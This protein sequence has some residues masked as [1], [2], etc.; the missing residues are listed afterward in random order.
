[1]W[2][3]I[4][5][6]TIFVAVTNLCYGFNPDNVQC[7]N[8]MTMNPQGVGSVEPQIMP[9]PY[10]IHVA[11][12]DRG[13][14]DTRKDLN[15]N[16]TADHTEKG[17]RSFMIQARRVDPNRRTG[18]PIG[19]FTSLDSAVLAVEDCPGTYGA[20]LVSSDFS[21][22]RNV[23]LVWNSFDTFQGH[24][25]FRVTFVQDETTF[26]VR[27]KSVTIYDPN[28]PI[29]EM[30][31][32][33][34]ILA[35]IRTIDV[36]DCGSKKGCYRMPEGCREIECEYIV[37]WRNINAGTT[38]FEMSAITDGFNDRYFALGLSTDIYMGDD[39]VFECVHN[40]TS[41]RVEVFQSINYKD[42]TN[43]RLIKPK[44]GL[45]SEEGSYNN[46]R[47]RCRFRRDNRVNNEELTNYGLISRPWRLLMARGP[48]HRGNILPHDIVVGHLPLA[49]PEE[50]SL[51]VGADITGR[52]RYHLVKAHACLMLLAWIFF[53]PI[54]L[55]WMKYYTTMWPN[56]R[57]L[58]QKY[59]L[60]THFNCTV[61]V[62]ILV[63]ISVIL[64]F[65]EAGGWSYFHEL[66]Q[67]A[68]PILGIIVFI[69]IIVI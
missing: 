24:L 39:L 33:E 30:K 13:Q 59:W 19:T 68:H 14:Y 66:P 67:K 44:D 58:G 32:P 51:D 48:S 47:L 56:S 5:S 17:F 18:E 62:V 49:S 6:L 57:F 29:A 46:G 54:G 16:L 3:Q 23:R 8:C 61:W 4:T 15:V 31:R 37:T 52:A 55:I 43:K 50:V 38:E 9:S 45:L 11:K 22:K 40:H 69:C 21:E 27:E 26:W 10:V 12:I 65:I 36:T 64:I 34:Y 60:V 28:E 42:N 7:C 63:I 53:A 1:M 41:G 35:P 2:Q 25:E 20:A